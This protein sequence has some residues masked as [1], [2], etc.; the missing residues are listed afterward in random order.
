MRYLKESGIIN[1][2]LG[3]LEPKGSIKIV[4]LLDWFVE[5]N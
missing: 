4:S 5:K 2:K 1:T 3:I